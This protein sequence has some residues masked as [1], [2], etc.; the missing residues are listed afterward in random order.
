M[1][2]G[3]AAAWERQKYLDVLNG[4]VP[5]GFYGKFDISV[6]R[7]LK[8]KVGNRFSATLRPWTMC[9]FGPNTK[10]SLPSKLAPGRYFIALQKNGNAVLFGHSAAAELPSVYINE[11]IGAFLLKDPNWFPK[12]AERYLAERKKAKRSTKR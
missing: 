3:T 2:N 11:C 1:E 10:E 9:C 8:G 7:V 4:T 12:E 5:G 6:Q